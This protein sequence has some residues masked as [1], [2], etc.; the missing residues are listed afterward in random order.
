MRDENIEI[1]WAPPRRGR[2]DKNNTLKVKRP[3]LFHQLELIKKQKKNYKITVRSNK[4]ES[5]GDNAAV[6]TLPT[7]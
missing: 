1:Y 5:I 4:F 6:N 2:K 7:Q 3:V